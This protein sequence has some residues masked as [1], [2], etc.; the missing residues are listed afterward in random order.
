MTF[1]YQVQST[2]V[3]EKVLERSRRRYYYGLY[4]WKS[5]LISP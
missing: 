2:E 5:Y 4:W 1:A 3:N